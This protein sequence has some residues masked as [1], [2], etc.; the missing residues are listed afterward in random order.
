MQ[1]REDWLWDLG[2]QRDPIVHV[3]VVLKKKVFGRLEFLCLFPRAL[4]GDGGEEAPSATQ[5]SPLDLPFFR[6]I[7]SNYKYAS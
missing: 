6:R 1:A 2:Q 5:V 7:L 4:A 3:R